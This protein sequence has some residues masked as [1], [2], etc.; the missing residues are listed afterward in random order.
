LRAY[1]EDGFSD[2]VIAEVFDETKVRR[3]VLTTPSGLSAN[4]IVGRAEP[5]VKSNNLQTIWMATASDS[6]AEQAFGISIFEVVANGARWPDP[7]QYPEYWARIGIVEQREKPEEPEELE[8]AEQGG[9]F[10][11]IA[12]AELGHPIASVEAE[13]S[14][15]QKAVAHR[16]KLE[17]GIT[18]PAEYQRIMS[19]VDWSLDRQG[20][21]VREGNSKQAIGAREVDLIHLDTTAAG[22]Q[23]NMTEVNEGT[24]VDGLDAT[25]RA[26]EIR[27]LLQ[28]DTGDT[29]T[30]SEAGIVGKPVFRLSNE[31]G[32]LHDSFIDTEDIAENGERLFEFGNHDVIDQDQLAALADY[33]WKVCRGGKHAYAFS[34]DGMQHWIHPGGRYLLQIGSAGIAENIDSVVEVISVSCVMRKGTAPVTM[35]G[36]V[37]VEENWKWDSNAFARYLAAGNDTFLQ[38]RNPTITIASEFF[39]GPADA[40]IAIGDTSAQTKINAAIDAAAD[41]FGGRTVRLTGGIYNIDGS[42]NM[43]DGVVLEGDGEKTIIK[44]SATSNAPHIR[45]NG[46][47]NIAIRNITFQQTTTQPTNVIHATVGSDV[48]VEGCRIEMRV[49]GITFGD[50]DRGIIKSCRFIVTS[51]VSATHIGVSSAAANRSNDILI[52]GCIFDGAQ[53][54]VLGSHFVIRINNADKVQ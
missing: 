29:V 20:W 52:E 13:L 9:L 42:I 34:V 3:G 25:T 40:R 33:Y 1:L 27:V 45:A 18:T 26:G 31:M 7:D 5:I 37:E 8:K 32:Y 36:A 30:M 39:V 16:A 4:K 6:F 41:T 38:S 24:V 15:Q 50:I 12:E 17:A 54:V 28:N 22:S 35:I 19:R 23:S 48:T 47:S 21:L 49:G 43:K 53:V 46:V 14:P 2:P 44:N 51:T 10:R 11:Q